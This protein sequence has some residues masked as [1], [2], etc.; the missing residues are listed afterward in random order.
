MNNEFPQ[1]NFSAKTG[2]IKYMGC[3]IYGTGTGY[4]WGKTEYK[5]FG[6]AVIAIQETRKALAKS[7][8]TK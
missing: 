2:I 5:T 7:I 8:R 4:K 6:E 3:L 1:F